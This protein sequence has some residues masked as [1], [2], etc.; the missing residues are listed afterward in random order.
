MALSLFWPLQELILI[1]PGPALEKG[2]K[3]LDFTGVFPPS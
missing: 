1:P 3:I 2:G